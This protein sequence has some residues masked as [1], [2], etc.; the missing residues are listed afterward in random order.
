M[1][2]NI[3]SWKDIDW[4]VAVQNLAYSEDETVEDAAKMFGGQ[5]QP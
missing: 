5:T 3:I 4:L 2:G 1:N